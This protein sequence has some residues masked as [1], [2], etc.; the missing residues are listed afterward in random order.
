[1]TRKTRHRP[2]RPG[3]G[4]PSPRHPW[5]AVFGAAVRA[6][7]VHKGLSQA[8]TARQLGMAPAVYG[9]I[10][11]GLLVPGVALLCQICHLLEVSPDTLLVLEYGAPRP[12]FRRWRTRVA[13]EETFTPPV[14]SLLRKVRQLSPAQLRRLNQITKLLFE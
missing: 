1:M 4:E 8:E 11:R 7:R 13:I 3:R 12:T 10:E 14:S 6:A 5:I 2:E 9:R